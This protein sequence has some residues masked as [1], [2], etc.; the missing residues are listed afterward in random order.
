MQD[1][2]QD[3]GR[4]RD[5]DRDQGTGNGMAEQNRGYQGLGMVLGLQES[6]PWC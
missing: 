5:W 4:G 1:Q 2:D 3:Q 6:E